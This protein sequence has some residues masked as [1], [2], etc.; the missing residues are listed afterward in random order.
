MPLAGKNLLPSLPVDFPLTFPTLSELAQALEPDLQFEE[1]P[2]LGLYYQVS[3]ERYLVVVE[4]SNRCNP[5]WWVCQGVPVTGPEECT[6]ISREQWLADFSKLLPGGQGG[7]CRCC[8]PC[9][10]PPHLPC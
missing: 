1:G 4:D 2:L 8:C 10:C 9:P 3:G 6:R 7:S 5:D